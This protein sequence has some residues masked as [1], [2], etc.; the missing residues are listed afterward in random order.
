MKRQSPESIEMSSAA[1]G[2]SILN[3]WSTN[4]L[5]TVFLVEQL[6]VELWDAAIPGSP[7]RTVR[8][9]AGHIHNARCGWIKTLG[10]PHGIAVP[11]R[12]D[13]RRVT[14]PQLSRA[15]KQS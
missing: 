10:A 7:R 13:R 6:P 8:M 2:A 14:R 3:T 12:V 5:I 11:D 1:L 4:N 15:L 9:L